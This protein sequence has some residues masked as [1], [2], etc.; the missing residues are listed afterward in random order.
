[1]TIYMHCFCLWC[2]VVHS[3]VM[4][5]YYYFS[6]N[7]ICFFFRMGLKDD[8][9]SRR[10]RTKYTT[11]QVYTY[12]NNSI[13]IKFSW[14]ISTPYTTKKLSTIKTN[15]FFKIGIWK[16]VIS[17]IIMSNQLFWFIHLTTMQKYLSIKLF[18]VKVMIE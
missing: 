3:V 7:F 17:N 15:A 9:Q 11:E 10:G 8:L 14:K 16:G 4:V 13:M 5:L 12:Y 1:M 6:F 18:Y 2:V